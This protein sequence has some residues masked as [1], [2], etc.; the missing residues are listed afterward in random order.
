MFKNSSS[1]VERYNIQLH[2][3]PNE[4]FTWNVKTEFPISSIV[5]IDGSPPNDGHGHVAEIL[6]AES[7]LWTGDD[8][9]RFVREPRRAIVGKRATLKLDSLKVTQAD[10]DDTNSKCDI[11]PRSQEAGIFTLSEQSTIH[12]R[13]VELAIDEDLINVRGQAFA[14]IQLDAGTLIRRAT[15]IQ[16][17]EQPVLAV[18]N[19]AGWDSAGNGAIVSCNVE[20]DDDVGLPAAAGL[21]YLNCPATRAVVPQA[22][23]F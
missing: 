19:Y 15:G 14:R 23:E 13:L 18:N 4:P 16:H 7:L 12:F 1:Y 5:C 17:G 8:I 6:M 22:F 2:A 10:P 20:L 11:T 21:T 9:G 3:D